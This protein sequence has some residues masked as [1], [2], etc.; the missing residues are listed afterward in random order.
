MPKID[1]NVSANLQKLF[2]LPPCID[3]SLP[4]AAKLQVT[5]P[6]GGSLKAISDISKGIP[7]DCSL[8]VSLMLQLAPFLAS[9]DCLLKLLGVIGPLIEVI[10]A[11]PDPIKLGKTV[12]KFISAAEKLA[13]C[14]LVVTGAPLIPF[15]RDLLCLILKIIHCLRT[16]LQS[17]L[18]IMSGLA[19]RI[20]VASD[21]GN[22]ELMQALQCAQDNA[23]TSA[24][25]MAA[26]IEPVTV[27]LELSAPL[28][29]LAGLPAIKLPAMGSQ[30]DLE[31]L[32]KSV[33]TLRDIEE[34]IQA[35][36]D[37]PIVGGCAA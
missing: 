8:V 4:K 34:I 9:I 35:V 11:V 25:H 16:Q 1:I 31:S 14:L 22:T 26:S 23:A 37:L 32:Q 6:T 36:V 27:L 17:I 30:A 21:A 29:E 10:K 5:L 7:N 20:K 13:P 19:L 2:E 24:Q 12:P 18:E 3:L 15:L 28:M 33:Q